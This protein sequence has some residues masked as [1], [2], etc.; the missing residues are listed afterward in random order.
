MCTVQRVREHPGKEHRHGLHAR[1]SCEVDLRSRA[2]VITA[3]ALSVSVL[4]EHVARGLG[5]DLFSPEG[6]DLLARTVI[7]IY[8]H[9]L[10][11]L[12]DAASALAGLD[13]LENPS[14]T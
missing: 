12:Q 6:A 14:R 3:M 4:Q 7:D 11:S 1:V 5:V 13:R 10:M 2:T 9:P 8:S